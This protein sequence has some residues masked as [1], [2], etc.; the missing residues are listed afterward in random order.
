[1]VEAVAPFGLAALHGSSPTSAS[2]AT[3]GGGI[4]WYARALGMATNS[5]HG[6]E[7]V[8]ADGRLA[9]RRRARADLFWAVRGGGG[10]FGVVTAMVPALPGIETAYAGMLVWDRRTPRRCPA[11]AR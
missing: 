8:T 9:R 4:G 6:V 11:W 7:L 5:N 3:L 1:M 10:N 2:S